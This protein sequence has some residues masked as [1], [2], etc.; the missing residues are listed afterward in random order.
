MITV[1]QHSPMSL[2]GMY[3]QF[4]ADTFSLNYSP[5]YAFNLF[6]KKMFTEL[7][8]AAHEL[9]CWDALA[10]QPIEE[11]NEIPCSQGY[12]L[13][14]SIAGL[15]YECSLYLTAPNDDCKTILF[16][17]AL[18]YPQ[19]GDGKTVLAKVDLNPDKKWDPRLVDQQLTAPMALA[20]TY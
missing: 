1:K 7:L 17:V 16:T 9:K 18:I 2:E 10:D 5:E 4:C 8:S 3:Q 11:D 15:S 13:P 6:A 20:T 19:G 12:F 14:V